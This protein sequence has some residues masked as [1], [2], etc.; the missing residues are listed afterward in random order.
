MTHSPRRP[1]ILVAIFAFSVVLMGAAQAKSLKGVFIKANYGENVI[2]LA[3]D[4]TCE[5]SVSVDGQT[6]LE[7]TWQGKDDTVTY[8]PISGAPEGYNCAEAG[9]YLRW[10]KD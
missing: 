6:F 1:A 7:S 10:I 5:Q 4:S 9:K 8:S 3:F 2:G